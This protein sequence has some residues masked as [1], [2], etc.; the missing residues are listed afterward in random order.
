[1][2]TTTKR[3]IVSIV[4]IPAALAVIWFGGFAFDA[5]LLLLSALSLREFYAVAARKNSV[6]SSKIGL[7]FGFVLTAYC[8]AL[9]RKA[10]TF[11]FYLIG[12]ILFGIFF[13]S[14]FAAELIRGPRNSLNNAASNVM[15]LFYAG[16]PYVAI[17]FLRNIDSTPF[18]V[19][20]SPIGDQLSADPGRY[21]TA[22]FFF[23]VWACDTSAYFFGKKFGKRKLAP[24]ISPHKTREGAVAGFAASIIVFT[25]FSAIFF[26]SF[27]VVHS[28]ALG[29]II[30]IFGQFGDLSES[31]F[32]RDASAKDSSRLIPGHGGVLDRMDSTIFA[33]PAAAIYTTIF[34]S[35]D[36]L[37]EIFGRLV[38]N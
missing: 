4:I 15:G 17:K 3:I 28:L 30:G 29:A 7:F 35:A 26:D 14:V 37:I 18:V 2:S 13:F 32:K 16:L 34:L 27:P 23:A 9:Y 19:D 12:L 31:L 22:T 33:A 5:A 21:L 1:M 38:N 20:L 6:K 25:V 36:S 24:K 8:L 10:D 11:E